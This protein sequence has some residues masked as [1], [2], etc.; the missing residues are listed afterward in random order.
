MARI[1]VVGPGAVGGAIAAWLLKGGHQVLLAARTQY[2]ELQVATPSGEL[3]F[4]PQYVGRSEQTSADWILFATKAYDTLE[5]R[6]W[7]SCVD[8]TTVKVA[9][10]QNGVEH[11]RY[12]KG[13]IAADQLLPVVVDLPAERDQA[14][15]VLQRKTG[16]LWV[17]NHGLGRQFQELFAGSAGVRIEYVESFAFAAW[18]KLSLNAAGAVSAVTLIPAKIAQNHS[19]A[20]LIS[21]IVRECMAVAAAEGVDLPENLPDEVVQHYRNSAPD[22]INSLHA[23]RLAGR[24]MEVDARNGVICR[25]GKRHGIS[26]P[27]NE[28]IV[29]LLESTR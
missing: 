2:A 6:D 8:P 16:Q 29:R 7:L 22:S 25:L 18:R 1:V 28:L 19:A 15:H 10:L 9:I 14:G 20:Q 21:D 17:E 27:I 4:T 26:T 24:Q 12:F 5:A 23:D 13:M 11:T 3:S